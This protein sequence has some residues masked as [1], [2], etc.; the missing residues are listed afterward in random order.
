MK[1][2]HALAL[3]GIQVLGALAWLL[4]FTEWSERLRLVVVLV[5]AV[6]YTGLVAVS[7]FQVFSGLAPFDLSPTA[8]LVL[9]TSAILLVAAWIAALAG[10]RQTLVH[11]GSRARARSVG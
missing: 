11:G 6:C 10:L 1:Q 5:A 3:H 9:G 2:P 4:L 8:G 7:A